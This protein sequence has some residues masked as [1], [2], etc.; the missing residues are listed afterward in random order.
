MTPTQKQQISPAKA[1]KIIGTNQPRNKERGLIFLFTGTGAGKTTN[2]LGIAMRCVGHKRKVVIIQFLKWWKETGEYR[3][4]DMLKPYYE[5]HQFGREGWVGFKNLDERD[6][7]LCQ[8]GMAL[9]RKV[10]A[11]QKPAVLIL[12]EINIALHTKMLDKAEVLEFVTHL[13]PETDVVMTGRYA[14]EEVWDA[15]DFV[16]VIMDDKHPR[17]MV[18]VE[19]INY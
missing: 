6:R 16:T 19:G 2:A 5:I 10:V 18:S 3:I 14:P 8:E 11:E 4:R 13:P 9:A 7:K 12:D 1:E 15:A 17:E